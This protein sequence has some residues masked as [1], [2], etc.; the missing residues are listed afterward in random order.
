MAIDVNKL[1]LAGE[2]GLFDLL[3]GFIDPRHRHWGTPQDRERP[4]DKHLRGT[5]WS[6][7]HHSD[8]RVG[9]RA[10]LGGPRTIRLEAWKAAERANLSA[11]SR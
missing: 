6:A 9:S 3:R 4:G 11:R 2:G 8:G 1:P 7:E 5:C 10:V